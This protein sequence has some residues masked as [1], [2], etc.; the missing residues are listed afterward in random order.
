VWTG[1]PDKDG[2]GIVWMDGKWARVHRLVWEL[3]N[4]PIPLDAKGKA[5]DL[6]HQCRNRL[7]C[8][9]DHLEP[10]T[11]AENVRR[12]WAYRARG[13]RAAI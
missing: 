1:T 12:M 9:L 3:A 4:G 5:L 7:C 11:R 10:V 8:K 13:G 2:Y 6:D